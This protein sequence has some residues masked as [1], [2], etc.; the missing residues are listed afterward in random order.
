MVNEI[1]ESSNSSELGNSDDLSSQIQN[2]TSNNDKE[3]YD[4]EFD[5]L[6]KNIDVKTDKKNT[7]DND[8]KFELPEQYKNDDGSANIEQILKDNDELSKQKE[9]LE[10]KA[11]L[12]DELKAEREQFAKN[13]GFKDYETLLFHQKEHSTTIEQAQFEASQYAKY[14]HTV[15]NADD[16]RSLLIQYAQAPTPYLLK[17]IEAEFDSSTNKEVAKS[18]AEYKLIKEYET[19]QNEAREFITNAVEKHKEMFK[20]NSF[21]RLFRESIKFAGNRFSVDELVSIVKEIGESAVQKYI[22]EQNLIKENENNKNN[23]IDNTPSAQ[24][25]NSSKITGNLLDMS[26]NELNLIIEKNI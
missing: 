8:N 10:T 18:L 21:K 13:L 11:K 12:A 1:L 2:E 16:V 6:D 3:Q 7:E 9:E 26:E 20:D 5:N 4:K 23:L 19:Y 17:Q 25:S 14:L 24:T 15:S 22:A